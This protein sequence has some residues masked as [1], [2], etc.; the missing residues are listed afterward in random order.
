MQRHPKRALKN[1]EVHSEEVL[2]FSNPLQFPE[3]VHLWLAGFRAPVTST[4][5]P[6]H[7]GSGPSF[8]SAFT[9]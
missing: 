4:P 3:S 1:P 6:L 7:C 2:P 9:H 5:A 8:P